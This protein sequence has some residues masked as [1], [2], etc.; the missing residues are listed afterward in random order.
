[1]FD[2]CKIPVDVVK[3]SE[4][5]KLPKKSNPDDVGFDVCSHD[6]TFELKPNEIKPVGTG[7]RMSFKRYVK[8]EV[9]PRSGLP[10]KGITV[11]NSPGTIEGNYRNEYKVILINHSD[12]PFKIEKGDRIA[13]LCFVPA[14][15]AEFNIVNELSESDRGMNGLGSS[16]VK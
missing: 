15:D 11:A 9:L 14:F 7:L 12:K 4:D 13:Q 3:L 10:L 1:M 2:Y 5:A 16:G 8:C 6:E